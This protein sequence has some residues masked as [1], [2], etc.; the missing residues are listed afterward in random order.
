MSEFKINFEG[1]QNVIE[2]QQQMEKT[3][4]ALREEAA[5]IKNSLS[6]KVAAREQIENRLTQLDKCME[7]IQ[8]KKE[9]MRTGL[10][11]VNSTY[12]NTE[13]KLVAGDAV[14]AVSK[15]ASAVTATVTGVSDVIQG[16]V[17]NTAEGIS[18]Y[19][20]SFNT[21]EESEQEKGFFE[22]LGDYAKWS[23][24]V[25]TKT[26][27]ICGSNIKQSFEESGGLYIVGRQLS[28][29]LK[30]GAGAVS[31]MS[32]TTTPNAMSVSS[33]AYGMNNISSGIADSMVV[34]YNVIM[35]ENIRNLETQNVMKYYFEEFGGWVGTQYGNEELGREVGETLYY[36]G[37]LANT[38][39]SVRGA[40]QNLAGAD[41][42][43]LSGVM[44]EMS[45]LQ[46]AVQ[47]SSP[48]RVFETVI[49]YEMPNTFNMMQN[50][51]YAGKLA[52]KC[53]GDFRTIALNTAMGNS[54]P[55]GGLADKVENFIS[56]FAKQ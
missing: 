19:V 23:F 41:S 51:V 36:T 31:V 4:V 55:F 47:Q 21:A 48:G 24:G 13:I 50:S 2:M 27:E 16:A 42:F 18:D 26:A 38:V 8:H 25:A 9:A 43:K 6:F 10:T 7:E 35:G 32:A 5:G 39:Y 14:D 22:K 56:S 52:E 30:V 17:A 3:F 53:F 46:S 15:M 40:Y 29:V 37:D 11:T 45:G 1:V 33:A 49:N 54:H 20:S 12:R 28:N 34:S 44:D